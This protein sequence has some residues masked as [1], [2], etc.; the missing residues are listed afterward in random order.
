MA[1][2]PGT[3]YRPGKPCYNHVITRQRCT[4]TWHSRVATELFSLIALLSNANHAAARYQVLA[5]PIYALWLEFSLMHSKTLTGGVV[6]IDVGPEGI[7]FDVHIE[8]IC[9]FSPFFDKAL[10]GRCTQAFDK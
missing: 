5:K 7:P 6:N 1:H 2:R 4:R 9:A 8:L 10:S 3:Y